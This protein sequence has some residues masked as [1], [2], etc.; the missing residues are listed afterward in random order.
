MILTNEPNKLDGVM[1]LLSKNLDHYGLRINQKKV[2]LWD[3]QGLQTYRCRQLHSIFA[4]KEFRND[5]ARVRLFV[6]G[7]LALGDDELQA[8]WNEGTPLLNRLIWANI[9]SLPNNLYE[10]IVKRF[11]SRQYI[12]NADHKKLKRIFNLNMRLKKPLDFLLYL[13]DLGATTVHNS[14]HFEVLQF[15]K[16]NKHEELHGYFNERVQELARQIDGCKIC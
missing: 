15:C 12:L 8:S 10:Q 14:Y 2:K 16:I 11:L 4:E 13:Q 1:L 5:P 9:E 3:N 7:Y 6:D